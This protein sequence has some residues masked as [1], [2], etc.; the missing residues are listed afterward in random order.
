MK[1]RPILMCAEMVRATLEGR[2]TQ[3]RR[4]R[5]L[6]EINKNPDEWILSIV[7]KFFVFIRNGKTISF[8][9]PYGQ[10]GDRLWV[11]ETYGLTVKGWSGYYYKADSTNSGIYTRIKWRSPMHM[12]RLASRITLEITALRVERLQEISEADAIKEGIE[13]LFTQGEC[14]TT[15]G[16]KGTQQKEHGYRNYLWHGN[17]DAPT[18]LIEEWEYQYSSCDLG[19]DSFSSLWHLLNAKRGYGWDK[20]PWVW[21]IEFRKIKP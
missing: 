11:R 19:K 10:V 4:T 17:H 3:T 13:F 7:N 15:V 21:V 6:E 20:N 16:I 1:E 18:K 9:C 2:K 12:P 14:N 5:G 8:S